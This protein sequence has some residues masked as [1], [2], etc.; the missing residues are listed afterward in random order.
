MR[1]S[2]VCLQHSTGQQQLKEGKVSLAHSPHCS[3]DTVAGAGVT[4]HTESTVGKQRWE[5]TGAQLAFSLL[6]SPGLQPM[7][8]CHLHLGW[9]SHLRNLISVIPH[10]H[11]PEVCVSGDPKSHQANDPSGHYDKFMLSDNKWVCFSERPPQPP[12]E[13]S[14]AET[15]SRDRGADGLLV[16]NCAQV[17]ASHP[18]SVWKWT[19]YPIFSACFPV[20]KQ[21]RPSFKVR[22]Y[23][24]EPQ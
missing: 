21:A 12:E 19:L 4:G 8:W 1:W 7:G 23:R 20:L 3:Q 11:D 14:T 5:G 6:F 2:P 24:N 16:R 18:V 15:Q 17:L 9:S 13:G 10:R 22:D